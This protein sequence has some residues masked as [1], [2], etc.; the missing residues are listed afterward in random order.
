MRALI[1]RPKED[2]A[3]IAK[4]LEELGIEPVIEPLMTVELVTE[5]KFDLDA[6]QAILLTSRNGVRALASTTESRDVVVFAVGDSTAELAREFGFKFVESASG[7]SESLSA[8]VRQRLNPDDGTLLHAVGT[9]VAGD[10]AGMLA[11]DGFEVR[12]QEL[13]TAQPV[14][15]LSVAT[16]GMLSKDAIDLVLFFSPRTAQTFVDLVKRAGLAE[17]CADM[18]AVCLSRAVALAVGS[19]KWREVHIS[20]RPDLQ[21][22]IDVAASVKAEARQKDK[23]SQIE[24]E[25]A[26]AD[27]PLFF[28]TLETPEHR[29]SWGGGAAA[30]RSKR[31]S[32]VWVTAVTIIVVIVVVGIYFWPLMS[33]RLGMQPDTTAAVDGA[34]D[35]NNSTLRKMAGRVAAI[36]DALKSLRSG[37]LVQLK[38]ASGATAA[39]LTRFAA[40]L[41]AA[42]KA[43]AVRISEAG[44]GNIAA[45]YARINVL[46]KSVSDFQSV[47]T[48]HLDELKTRVS[49][50]SLGAADGMTGIA[51]LRAENDRLM[52]GFAAMSRR[53]EALEVAVSHPVRSFEPVRGRALVLAVGQ[54]RQALGKSGPFSATL[55][56]L[57]AVGGADPLVVSV[58]EVLTPLAATGVDTKN[59]LIVMFDAAASEAARAAI[60]PEGSSWIDR[61]VQRLASVITIR[62]EGANVEGDSAQALLARA[63]ARLVA[64]DLEGADKVLAGLTGRAAAAMAV[65][66][67]KVASRI[68][69]DGA[70][71]RLSYHAIQLLSGAS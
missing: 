59:R 16:C 4:K 62:R 55:N 27:P 57:R 2:S 30:P 54:L 21:S 8:L 15:A 40:R 45:I 31:R 44:N 7:D 26:S 24:N 19:L 36:E 48:A 11:S 49:G 17:A 68:A 37:P 5:A 38:T 14:S 56:S 66:R 58:L 46:E 35:A 22:M 23:N 6:V 63:E 53:L 69:A 60:A 41:E 10:I 3:T 25:D 33:E 61:T 12:R 13:Y 70:L 20:G 43:L 52:T 9:A 67:G 1:T 50:F 18:T 65:W 39:E 34:A 47:L 64:R 42:E 29:Q 71:D 32:G 51:Q 28:S